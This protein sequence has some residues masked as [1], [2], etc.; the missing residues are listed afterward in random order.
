MFYKMTPLDNQ[1]LMRRFDKLTD[2]T[3]FKIEA[4]YRMNL[5]KETKKANAM[6]T[7]LGKTKRVIIADTLLE[8]FGS[9][10]IE[11]VFAHELGHSVRNHLV[12]G[13]CINSVLTVG[14]L[15]LCDLF[16]RNA[17]PALGHESYTAVSALPLYLFVLSLLGTLLGPLEKSIT[18]HFE[19]ESDWYAL[20]RTGNVPAF[21]SA[22]HRLAELNKAD[23]APPRL[24]VL[25]FHDHPPIAERLAM[26][27]RWQSRRS[28]GSSARP[29]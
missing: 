19:R 17:A 4:T 8:H 21:N 26:A 15:F 18:R 20:E 14:V 27:Q 6:L 28:A 5:S 11:V 3:A 25:L 1:E 29:V 7:G 10:E 22:F 24:V 23:L 12:K 9:D 16:I 13:I 2:G